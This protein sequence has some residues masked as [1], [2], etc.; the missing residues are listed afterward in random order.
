MSV[1]ELKQQVERYI[2][3]SKHD[4][5]K[6]LGSAIPEAK[7]WD[8]EIPQVDSIASPTTT[9]VSDM[10]PSP[11]K[12]QGADDI[13]SP[14]PGYQSKTEIEDRGTPQADSTALPAMAD[15]K[16]TQLGPVETPPWNDTTVPLAKPD[17][18]TLKDLLTAQA[19]SPAKLE[20]QVAPTTGSVDKLA[21]PPT[22]S[23]HV[24]KER[25]CV[26]T[27]TASMEMLNFGAL[28]MATGHQGAT[29]EELAEEDLVEGCP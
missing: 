27:V 15:A 29:V 12:T 28:S 18:E 24:V 25:W 5:L 23:S 9:D 8:M 19:A 22:P 10:W 17:T 13:I 20:N 14:L 11:M 26:S 6:D 2:T 7:G 4:I 21:G 3:F 16:D 1:V